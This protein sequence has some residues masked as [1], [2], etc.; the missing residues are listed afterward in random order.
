MAGLFF[1]EKEILF[2]ISKPP[3]P[4]SPFILF[5]VREKHPKTPKKIFKNN[6]LS[7]REL[8]RAAALNFFVWTVPRCD[9]SQGNS[10]HRH[11]RAGGD[12]VERVCATYDENHKMP[13]SLLTMGK[14]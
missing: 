9:V 2:F 6:L 12:P 7:P 11:P 5:P 13:R 14:L 3:P 8:N 1:F 4:S 10:H